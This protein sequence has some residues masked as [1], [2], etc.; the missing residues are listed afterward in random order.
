MEKSALETLKSGFLYLLAAAAVA[1]VV[2][3][4]SII[5][6]AAVAAAP[7]WRFAA[8]GVAVLMFVLLLAAVGIALYAIFG[9]IRP[10]MRKLSEVDGRFRICYTGTTL[11][12]VGIAV[13]VPGITLLV[14][15][16][17]MFNSLPVGIGAVTGGF[18]LALLIVGGVVGLVG[19]I[20]TFVVGAFK[21][22]GKYRNPLYVV[23]GT[24]FAV[25]AA[26]LPL[27]YS[28]M[29]TIV[30]CILMYVAI[31]RTLFSS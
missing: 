15:D 18:S 4:L 11:M 24:L 21:L 16:F 19:H 10:G 22:Y 31:N 12:L 1:V 27:G 7:Y 23:A 13:L 26:L 5:I 25:D 6:I 3:A 2:V 30:G 17:F 28:G 9:K 29:F 14:V 8:A 20:L